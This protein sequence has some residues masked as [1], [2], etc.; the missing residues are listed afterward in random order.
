MGVLRSLLPPPLLC[1]TKESHRF[2]IVA[3]DD[4]RCFCYDLDAGLTSI[5]RAMF[6]RGGDVSLQEAA[7][8]RH[9]VGGRGITPQDQTI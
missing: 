1:K 5:K 2:R 3:T 6:E 4:N 9:P 7:E 8:H